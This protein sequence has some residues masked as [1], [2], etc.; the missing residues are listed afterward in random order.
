[1]KLKELAE[2]V[3][4]NFGTSGVRGLVKDLSPELCYA[5]TVAFIENISA[6]KKVAV[7]H[8]LRPSSPS[9]TQACM[10]AIRDKGIE[11]DYLGALPTPAIAH[12]GFMHNIPSIAIT[13]SHI[14]YDRNGIKFYRAD[15]EISKHDEISIYQSQVELPSQ[16]NMHSL[17]TVNPDGLKLYISRYVNYFGSD[18]LSGKTVAVYEHSSVARD[19]LHLIFQSLGAQTISLARSDE[20]VPIDTEAVRQQ[21]VENA[22]KWAK[23]YEFDMLV[24]TDGDGDRPLIAGGNGEW[25]RGDVIGVITAQFLQMSGVVT[26]V[27]SNTMLEKTGTFKKCVRTKIGS[28]YVIDAMAKLAKDEAA[29][30]CG[31]EANGGFLLGSKVVNEDRVLESLATRDAVL[32]M[33]A[34]L[35]ASIELGIPVSALS[36]KLPSRFTH[37][38][39]I[40][41]FSRK[42]SEDLLNN[43]LAD[44]HAIALLLTQAKEIVDRDST[45]GLRFTFDS[46]D[47]IH[48]RP[49]GNAP[50]LRCYTES[51]SPAIA[52]QLC[53]QAL[54]RIQTLYS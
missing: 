25:L 24:S 41:N 31:Y 1:M 32:P 48:V 3:N 14:P 11:V 17:P 22:L 4:V 13:G 54:S 33:L 12:Y 10:A 26:P 53:E 43:Q 49:S 38:D 37:S 47:I 45:D 16:I 52:K 9:I 19:I 20:F 29:S 35:G 28:P 40:Q 39:R 30:V 15:G 5:Y 23:Q 7:G 21:D 42:N 36:Q 46:G 50:E 44:E 51:S 27:S 8:D 34:I 18:Y 2:K 6:C